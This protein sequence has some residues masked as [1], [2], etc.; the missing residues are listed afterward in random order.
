MLPLQLIF[1]ASKVTNFKG[2]LESLLLWLLEG[3]ETVPN[4]SCEMKNRS[5]AAIVKNTL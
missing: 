1:I 4:Y 5:V 3:F 2:T